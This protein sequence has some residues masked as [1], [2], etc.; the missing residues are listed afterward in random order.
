M[1]DAGAIAARATVLGTGGA[2]ALWQRTTNP[3]GAI[4]AGLVLALEAG[5]A[6]A[7]LELMQ[8]HPR[9]SG[10]TGELDGFLVTEAVR[11][12]GALLLDAAVSASSTSWRRATRSRARSTRGCAP[13]RAPSVSTCAA[14]DTGALPQHRRE[15]SP[16]PGWT[17]AAT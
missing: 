9:R 8:F 10:S 2:A 3:R 14:I 4:G 1:T 16:A 17:R 12:E 5:A 7:D 6:L 15:S 13:V 11:G